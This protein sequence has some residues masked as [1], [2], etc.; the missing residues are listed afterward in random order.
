[1]NDK[2]VGLTVAGLALIAALWWFLT[3]KNEEPDLPDE[4][5]EQ[6]GICWA[7]V[8]GAGYQV[9][10]KV[11]WVTRGGSYL[12]YDSRTGINEIRKFLTSDSVSMYS[13][14]ACTL[15]YGKQLLTGWNN[16][17]WQE[18]ST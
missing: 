7:C 5:Q 17:V 14:A 9:G 11:I 18:F 1:M 12:I 2:I 10:E 13:I 3:R 4:I 6:L 8:A 15:P 16:F